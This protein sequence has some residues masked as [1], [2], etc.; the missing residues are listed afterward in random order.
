MDI[1]YE[2]LPLRPTK[3]AYYE[4]K[5]LKMDLFDAVKILEDG[6]DCATG[7]RKTDTIERCIDSKSKT[8]KVVAAKSYE[9]WSK[10]EVYVIT[11]VGKFARKKK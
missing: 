5:R 8:A 2:G 4:M 3:S 11:H 6:Y 7:K 1:L 10:Q 9:Y